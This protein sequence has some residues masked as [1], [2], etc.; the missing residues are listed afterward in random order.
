LAGSNRKHRKPVIWLQKVVVGF[1]AG[2]S[3]AVVFDGNKLMLQAAA[4]KGRWHTVKNG[5][6]VQQYRRATAVAE[7]SCRGIG[8][9]W[10]SRVGAAAI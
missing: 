10:T 9:R 6:R 2:F 7:I 4:W 5:G 1:A 3:G 8:S